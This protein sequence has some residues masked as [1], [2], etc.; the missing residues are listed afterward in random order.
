MLL[1][2]L[3]IFPVM[4]LIGYASEKF[5]LSSDLGSIGNT[6]VNIFFFVGVIV[7][8]L[9]HRIMCAIT[10][11]PAYNIKVKFRNEYSGEAD[12]HGSVSLRQRFQMSFLQAFLVSF[13]PILIGAWIIYFL[14]QVALNSLFNPIIRIIAV[15]CIISIIL[16]SSPSRADLSFI[17]FG[18]QNDPQHSQYQIFLVTISFLI[19][20]GL[21]GVY[22][23]ILPYEF[24]YYFII[25]LC[26]VILKYSFITIRILFNKIRGRKERIPSNVKRRLIRRSFKP[27]MVQRYYTEFEE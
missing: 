18:Y 8:E 26:Y 10:G 3:G 6:C 13:A 9:S 25:I 4:Y 22:N 24:L 21:V 2:S 16:A 17:K 20:W 14:L 7:H 12:P 5:L 11:V 27:E 1:I 19:S 15:F 23:I